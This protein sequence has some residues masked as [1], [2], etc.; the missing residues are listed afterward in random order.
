MEIILLFFW[1]I[2]CALFASVAYS[3]A[4][5]HI[6]ARHQG[7]KVLCISQGAA[8]G[9]LVFLAL[10]HNFSHNEVSDS[11]LLKHF[12]VVLSLS[13]GLLTGYLVEKLSKLRNDPSPLV[14]SFFLFLLALNNL[15]SAMFPALE[16]HMSQMFFGDL[17]TLANIDA[18]ILACFFVILIVWQFKRRHFD[19]SESFK[20][21][22]LEVK[23]RVENFLVIFLISL[24][25][26]YFGFLFTASLIFIPTVLLSLVPSSESKGHYYAVAGLAS[27]ASVG[28]FFLSIVS[29][30]LPTVPLIVF[31]LCLFAM[32]V[33]LFRKRQS[34]AF[35]R[36]A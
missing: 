30:K 28:G 8:L 34:Q 6:I 17:A 15:F 18:I 23:P 25:V 24:G 5:I 36:S 21:A 1:P 33:L 11:L 14:L 35:S 22:V 32:I 26:Q 10:G 16:T 20:Q 13:F 2:I 12:G 7:L 4:G 19:L 9:S 3:W 27:F 29:T 31:F